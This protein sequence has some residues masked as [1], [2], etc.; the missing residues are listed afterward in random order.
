MD[1]KF[2]EHYRSAANPSIKSLG[3]LSS[4]IDKLMTKHSKEDHPNHSGSKLKLEIINNS[5]IGRKIK[6][7]WLLSKNKPSLNSKPELNNLTHILLE[8]K[9]DSYSLYLQRP[10]SS[11]NVQSSERC[12][13]SDNSEQDKLKLSTILLYGE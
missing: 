7:A 1:S 6:E 2:V 10:I 4:F 5:L 9:F 3:V 12:S 8:F 13:I 11:R